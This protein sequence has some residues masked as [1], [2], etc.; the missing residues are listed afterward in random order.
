MREKIYYLVYRIREHEECPIIYG[1]TL[2]KKVLKAFLQQ[3]DKKKY[4][5]Y[6]RTEEEVLKAL[7]GNEPEKELMIE[8]L[9]IKSTESDEVVKLFMSMDELASVEKAIQKMMID[10]CS[11]IEHLK[12]YPNA[13]PAKYYL[14]L[15]SNMKVEYTDALHVAGYRPPEY[16]HMFPSSDGVDEEIALDNIEDAYGMVNHSDSEYKMSDGK[17]PGQIHMMEPSAGFSIDD[18]CK[19]VLYSLESFIMVMKND[20]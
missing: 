14:N 12:S 4:V 1:W 8:V 18:M 10:E 9:P 13:K 6:K 11:M 19:M 20:L 3:R 15:I 2:S 17:F 5:A 16:S 7:K